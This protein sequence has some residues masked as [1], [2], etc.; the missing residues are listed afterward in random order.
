MEDLLSP[1]P[2][3]QAPIWGFIVGRMIGII[4]ILELLS[5]LSIF[6][7]GDSASWQIIKIIKYYD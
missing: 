6:R 5:K 3:Q 1:A 2:I 7:V 4:A